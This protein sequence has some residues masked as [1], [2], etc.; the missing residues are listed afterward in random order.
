MFP[1]QGSQK[2][3]MGGE[4]F[5]K[6]KDLTQRADAI[7]GYS[8]K[9]LCLEDPDKQLG[10][11]QF[12]QPALYVVNALSYFDKI[13]E[14]GEKP[15]FVAGHSLGEFNALLAAEVFDFEAG[16]KLVKKRGELMS[17]VSGGGMAAVSNATKQEIESILADN[18]LNNIGLANFNTPSQIVISGMKDEIVK[19]QEF[20][21]SG[22]MMFHP[23]ATSGAF[24][25]KFMEPSRKKFETYLKKFKLAEPQIPVISN[26]SAQPYQS[27]EILGPLSSQ[28]ASSVLWSDSVEYLIDTA[29]QK[30]EEMEF[31]EVGHGNVLTG[32]VRK[33]NRELAK[34]AK[35]KTENDTK[36]VEAK[37]VDKPPVTSTE[38]A[39]GAS[40]LVHDWNTNHPVGTKVKSL[41]LDY[42]E[43]ETRTEAVVLFG[44]RA[45]VYMKDY[46]GYFDL[47]EIKPL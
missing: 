4:L 5:D 24:H 10:Q 1:G 40:Q 9:E 43:L 7:L 12:T 41:S 2:K 26:V 14:T 17:G 29:A 34:T 32:L 16:L 8:I 39:S 15:D 36:K 37:P 42:E 31:V 27:D 21:Q 18:G 22:R 13:E 30:G 45:A 44:H 6:Y 25:S 3:G 35:N 23:L 11:T 47:T 20:F 46:N 19:A 33:I 38:N 28:I